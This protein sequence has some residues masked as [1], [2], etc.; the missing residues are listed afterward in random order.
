MTDMSHRFMMDKKGKSL[1]DGLN[2]TNV[3]VLSSQLRKHSEF[4]P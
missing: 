1:I 2:S 3:T 4:L